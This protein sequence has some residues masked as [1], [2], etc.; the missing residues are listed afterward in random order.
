MAPEAPKKRK[1]DP[2]IA[3]IKARKRQRLHSG[4]DVSNKVITSA[5]GAKIVHVGEPSI[6]RP[7]KLD[8]LAWNEVELPDRLDDFEGFYGLEE[9]E[10]VDVVKD[11]GT[12]ML[13]F[14]S[15]APKK[16]HVVKDKKVE[17]AQLDILVFGDVQ[18]PKEEVNGV[19]REDEWEGFSDEELANGSPADIIA[20][21]TPRKEAGAAPVSAVA[22]VTGVRK[23]KEQKEKDQPVKR[24]PV[25]EEPEED[26]DLEGLS[27]NALEEEADEEDVDTQEWQ[28]LNL[29][30][31][32][33][34]SLSK[35]KFS[36]P[37]PIQSASIPEALE[38]HDVIGKAATGSGKTL[39]FG[40]PILEYYLQEAQH[41]PAQ[42]RKRKQQHSPL[43]L[44]LA[45]TRELA[46]QINKHLTTLCSRDDFEGPRIA[47]LTGGLSMEKQ[48][49]QLASADIVIGT[50]GRLW[51]VISEGHGTLGWFKRIKF[52]VV[53][54]ADRLLSEGHF[55]EVEEILNVLER[56]DEEAHANGEED[57]DA[58]SGDIV[59]RQT[60]VFS[61]TFQKDLQQKLAV[62]KQGRGDLMGKKETLEYLLRKLRFREEKP[63]FI[64][65]NPVSQMATGLQEGLLECPGT[66]KDL[67]LYALALAHPGARIL[68][69]TNSINA[70][71]RLTP[72]LKNTN[73]PA[74]PL[75]SHMEQKARLR[76][77]ERFSGLSRNGKI[78]I[79]SS[80]EGAILVAT[81]VAARG[82]DIPAID[83]IIHYHLPR[84]ADAYVHRSGRSARA[85]LSG[86]SI[87]LCAPEEVAGTRRLIAKVH[88]KDAERGYFIRTL[89]INRKLVAKLKPRVTL[90]KQI[91]D[92]TMAKEKKHTGDSMMKQ[93]AEDLGVNYDSEELEAMDKGKRGRGAGR[94]KKEREARG[95]T[96]DEMGAMRA[97]LKQLLATRVNSGVSSRYLTSGGIDVE[98]ELAGRK[99][100]FLGSELGLEG[101]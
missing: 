4:K 5:R 99:G 20:R 6:K 101:F 9:I 64:D 38:G 53:D 22:N 17:I 49:R 34:G 25:A 79:S 23:E 19:E 89:D 81:D 3:A 30:P 83:L 40:I 2:K 44:I 70:V 42:R 80:T 24:K 88:A 75:H 78:N 33:L 69:F 90:A 48:Q 52:L 50:P 76:S 51:E 29:S 1:H 12:S 100:E 32:T 10:G 84:T 93:A 94:K 14:E 39:A 18:D 46:H 71:Q 43:A 73:L 68:V 54:E 13:R 86:K 65:V 91:A 95:L 56:E 21:A 55:K 82:L 59:E 61:A 67:Y 7:V 35:M 97:E 57:K 26:A 37:T 28:K 98:K 36:R 77:L 27:Y 96:K 85:Q 63:K 16:E 58:P 8:K 41:K 62:R 15:S 45:P 74:L 60:L 87:L 11:E 31:E 66:E 47:T 72:L 92:A